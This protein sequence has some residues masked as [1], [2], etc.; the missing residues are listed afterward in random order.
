[1]SIDKNTYRPNLPLLRVRFDTLNRAIEEGWLPTL[2]YFC[3]LFPNGDRFFYATHRKRVAAYLKISPQT[4]DFHLKKMIEVGLV[5]KNGNQ[6]QRLKQK[7]K[8][9]KS[10][11]VTCKDRKRMKEFLESRILCRAIAQQ[12]YNIKQQKAVINANRKYEMGIPLKKRE[13]NLVKK[14]SADNRTFCA[15]TVMSGFRLA[16]LLGKHYITAYR[17]LKKWQSYGWISIRKRFNRIDCSSYLQS[18]YLKSLE[19]VPYYSRYCPKTNKILVP[20]VSEVNVIA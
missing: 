9:N 10:F 18:I 5:K 15:D 19:I 4:A 2:S 13:Y 17:K 16:E 11:A 1:M 3:Q 8:S 14:Y 20:V 7:T 6:L 12:S